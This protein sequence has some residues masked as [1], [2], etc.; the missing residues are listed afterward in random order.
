ML[1]RVLIHRAERFVRTLSRA[2][3]AREALPA[4]LV[5]GHGQVPMYKDP[6]TL[7]RRSRDKSN[8]DGPL[9]TFCLATDRL[10]PVVR[11]LYA[12]RLKF[13]HEAVVTGFVKLS[14][15]VER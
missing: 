10:D 13:W 3:N 12:H 4:L 8:D 7:L 6:P 1:D 9:L 5:E 14:N 15:E 11:T 2:R